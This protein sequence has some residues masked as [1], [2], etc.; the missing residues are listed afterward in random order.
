MRAVM[1]ELLDALAF[2][3]TLL[4]VAGFPLYLMLRASA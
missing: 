1:E 4:L 2:M 3:V